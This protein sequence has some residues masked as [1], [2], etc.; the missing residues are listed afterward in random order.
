MKLRLKKRM[1]ENVSENRRFFKYIITGDKT[2]I[3]KYDD[4]E[5]VHQASKWR[6]QN[7]SKPKNLNSLKA[8][9]SDA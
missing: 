6:F 2:Q 8:I 1:L 9:P 3:Y 7:E 4:V 5:T